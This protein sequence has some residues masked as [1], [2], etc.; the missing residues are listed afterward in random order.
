MIEDQVRETRQLLARLWAEVLGV[1]VEPGADVFALGADSLAAVRVQA[2]AR[3]AGLAIDLAALFSP[4]SSS[5]ERFSAEPPQISDALIPLEAR[6]FYELRNPTPKAYN[7]AFVLDASGIG[8]PVLL[9]A[10]EQVIDA[11][12]ALR[13]TYSSENGIWH[14]REGAGDTA[15]I[16]EDC[17][18]AALPRLVAEAQAAFSI[19]DGPLACFI[20]STPSP[21]EQRLIGIFH[22][23][24]FD[25]ISQEIVLSDLR[26]RIDGAPPVSPPLSVGGW[27]SILQRAA[28][29]PELIAA[30]RYWTDAPWHEVRVFPT[31][32]RPLAISPANMRFEEFEV[33]VGAAEMRAVSAASNISAHDV[34]LSALLRAI[35]QESTGA[36]IA[37]DLC[38]HGREPF[39]Q[40][41]PSGTV[42]WLSTIF[43]ALFYPTASDVIEDMMETRR[44]FLAVPFRGVAWGMLR[45]MR[46]EQETL[47]RIP[48]PAVYF[49]YQGTARPPQSQ[50]MPQI[51]IPLGP[52][53]AADT[54]QPYV[55]KLYVEPNAH[56]GRLLVRWHSSRDLLNDAFD[57]DLRARFKS[58]VSQAMI[59]LRSNR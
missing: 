16:V 7:T 44:Q 58:K 55:L 22:H 20:V 35:D 57:R 18:D 13:T 25:A 33:A 27:A 28:D 45:W 23:L 8:R 10:V 9:Q 34:V 29:R 42:G 39:W 12:P 52:L 6:F 26:R 31:D 49:N 48:R 56:T 54:V 47:A 14:R 37:I 36:P 50:L 2:L 32:S 41:D 19:E 30:A 5:I 51:D 3:E 15:V 11:H 53:R 17:P 1:A 24:V 46:R 21:T 43:P 40:G 4:W 38:G 59:Q